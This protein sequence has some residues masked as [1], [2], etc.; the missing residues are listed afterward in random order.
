MGLVTVDL[1]NINIE[2]AEYEVV[3]ALLA[4]NMQGTVPAGVGLIRHTFPL[5]LLLL[6]QPPM[7]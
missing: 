3:D 2:G 4:A 1:M 5:L 6:W 7:R